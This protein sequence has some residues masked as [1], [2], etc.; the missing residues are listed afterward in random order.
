MNEKTKIRVNLTRAT[1]NDIQDWLE[2]IRTKIS[3]E[4]IYETIDIVIRNN[5]NDKVKTLIFENGKRIKEKTIYSIKE[6]K[7][8]SVTSLHSNQL[9]LKTITYCEQKIS[10]CK[11]INAENANKIVIKT[12]LTFSIDESINFHVILIKKIDKRKKSQINNLKFIVK[13]MFPNHLNCHTFIRSSIWNVCDDVILEITGNIELP[14]HN[15]DELFRNTVIS[16]LVDKFCI[17]N[18]DVSYEYIMGEIAK[19]ISP[20]LVNK[21]LS[22]QFGLKKMGYSVRPLDMVDIYDNILKNTQKYFVSSKIDGNRC[23]IYYRNSRLY[24]VTNELMH[25]DVK[26]SKEIHNNCI[27]ADSEIVKKTISNDC[28]EIN[29]YVFDIMYCPPIEFSS[30]HKENQNLVNKPYLTRIE[31]INHVIKILNAIKDNPS[32]TFKKKPIM[33]LSDIEDNRLY[34][35]II[36]IDSPTDGLIITEKEG[37]P[38]NNTIA[39][40]WKPKHYSTIDFLIRADLEENS[41]T[42]MVGCQVKNKYIPVK[43][44]PRDY[45]LAHKFIQK[46]NHSISSNIDGKIGEFYWTGKKWRLLR[47]REDRMIDQKRG[48][49]FGND[50]RTAEL[51]WQS[52]KNYVEMTEIYNI[53]IHAHIF[54][55][56]RDIFT[57]YIKKRLNGIIIFGNNIAFEKE[58]IRTLACQSSKKSGV[59]IF[60]EGYTETW[61]VKNIYNVLKNNTVLMRKLYICPPI[62]NMIKKNL[63]E[64]RNTIEDR[65]I[66]IHNVDLILVI[67]DNLNI[68]QKLSK[69]IGIIKYFLNKNGKVVF[70]N[71]KFDENH[72]NIFYNKKMELELY[73][74]EIASF[75]KF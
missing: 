18:T 33:D 15:I 1:N 12:K 44:S 66:P 8:S 22:N 9:T 17:K 4:C 74:P 30:F 60:T 54:T 43:F 71:H 68:D 5:N 21:Y 29:V 55:P 49:Y 19:Y 57:K 27:I 52:R 40:K 10:E 13:S 26:N 28:Y 61:I 39:Y 72:M 14:L 70:I 16:E 37:A 34:N 45:P 6:G 58:A 67:C 56:I 11:N 20:K 59:F 41:Y 35:S 32:L 2:E 53:N 75:V 24:L 3:N 63:K 47:I 25:I 46:S 48:N 69:I 36:D 7:Y 73:T 51:T 62:K 23:I 42:L 38:Y 65:G 31:Y 64:I 50:I